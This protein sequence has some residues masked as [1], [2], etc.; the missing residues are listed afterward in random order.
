[1]S[2]TSQDSATPAGRPSAGAV[3]ADSLAQS[4]QR[5]E[6]RRDL[7]PL[8]A[9][10]PI[11]RAH[12]GDAVPAVIFLLISTSA[13]LGISGAARLVVDHGLSTYGALNRTAA[14]A[15]TVVAV[16]AIATAGR[17]YFISRLGERVVADLR[18]AIYDHVLSLDQ[19]FFLKTRTG[20]VLSRLT[21]DLTIVESMVGSSASVALRN[22]LSLIGSISLLIVVAP[23]YTIYVVLL[24]P[25]ILGP[26]FFFGRRVRV[27]SSKAQDRFADAVGFA[28]ESLDALETVQAFGRERS[29]S[30]RFGAAVEAAF[31]ASMARVRARALMT[32]LVIVLMFAGVGAILYLAV[33][34]VFIQHTMSAGVLFQFFF[35][36]IFAAGSVGQLGEVMGEVQKAAGAMARISELLDARPGIAP[37]AD[38]RALPVP[39][40]GE[41]GF[42]QVT[43][44][45]PGRP[46]L[47]ALRD[48]TLS[49]RPG[50]RVALVGPSGAGKS[51]VLRLLLRFYDPQ[52]GAIRID[53]VDLRDAAP[54]DARARMAL[55]A[56]DAPLFSGSAHDNLR[57]GRE[58]ASL[59]EMRA[60][61]EA[62][63]AW[64]F[65]SALPE[66]LDTPIGERAKTLSGGQRQRL[67]I[68]RALVRDAPILLLDEATSALDAENERLVQRALDQAMAGRTTLVIAHRLATVLKADRIVVM[69]EGRVVEEGVHADL[70]AKGGLYARLAELQFGARAA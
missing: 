23:R 70:V 63:Q 67:A 46:D 38:P 69:D 34:A 2:E 19:A 15:A 30:G 14:I 13:S 66:G 42:E 21:T 18:K 44:A 52:A 35:L 55:V 7:R 25:L 43:F 61:A 17:F 49:V 48:F 65:L 11:V 33:T 4:A 9:L 1:M 29:V 28:G 53:G 64:T 22:A 57:F 32:V 51:T 41:I 68:A 20:E 60:A 8:G 10:W 45:Y 50:E 6:R 58:G 5:R 37:P 24:A 31:H 56:Q 62:A 16:L 27:L 39:A 12:S 26:L 59:E 36:A 40:R 54:A 47:P 3:L